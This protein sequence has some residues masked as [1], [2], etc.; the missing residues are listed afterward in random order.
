MRKLDKILEPLSISSYD[1][2]TFFREASPL[3]EFS[4]DELYCGKTVL[5]TIFSDVAL[6]LNQK[7]ITQDLIPAI[8]DIISNVRS[9]G[10]SS[11]FS[12]FSDD[13]LFDVIKPRYI[14]SLT[15]LKDWSQY[16]IS[17]LSEDKESIL[18]DDSLKELKDN[19]LSP[20]AKSEA[21]SE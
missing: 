11:E 15:E 14:Q 10:Y 2:N 18:A 4:V 8:N 1:V 17:R 7:R 9:S 21:K 19:V 3:D 13:Q 5:K 16:L 12:K 6:I 20:E